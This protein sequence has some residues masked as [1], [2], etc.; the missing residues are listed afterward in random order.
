MGS[1]KGIGSV[2]ARVRFSELTIEGKA[3]FGKE[4]RKGCCPNRDQCHPT[5]QLG[6]GSR[7]VPEVAVIRGVT[8]H[9]EITL[10]LCRPGGPGGAAPPVKGRVT[11]RGS[12]D[13]PSSGPTAMR[14]AGY[15]T[16]NVATRLP[17]HSESHRTVEVTTC[18]S[19][20]P[21]DCSEGERQPQSV[22]VV[23]GGWTQG[24]VDYGR[25]HV[26]DHGVCH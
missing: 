2:L 11:R 4:T 19:P 13:P 17:P 18:S 10:V 16:E 1:R 24:N 7:N 21:K 22:G 26:A 5:F 9:S 20:L 15:T 25:D 8:R 12:P 14:G 23:V 6:Q 3:G